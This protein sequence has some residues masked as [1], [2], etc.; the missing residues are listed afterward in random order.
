MKEY[1][2]VTNT[3]AYPNIPVNT[4]GVIVWDYTT[5]YYEVEFFVNGISIVQTASAKS[6]KFLTDEEAAKLKV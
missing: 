2:N 6:L 3:V 1:N 5:D 4:P